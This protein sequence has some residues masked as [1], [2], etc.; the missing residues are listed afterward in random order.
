MAIVAPR[1]APT[2][3][4]PRAGSAVLTAGCD[5]YP[6]GTTGDVVGFRQGCA[7]FVPHHPE[8]VARWARRRTSVL[9][10]PGLLAVWR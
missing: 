10:P 1:P 9:V 4:G 3:R 2:S 6:G 7:I 8:R 5:G